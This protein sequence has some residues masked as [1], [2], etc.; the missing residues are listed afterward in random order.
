[1]RIAVVV[2]NNVT[3]DSRVQKIASSALVRGHEVLVIGTSDRRA[4]GPAVVGGAPVV[5]VVSASRYYSRET[6]RELSDRR[7]TVRAERTEALLQHLETRSQRNRG[8][9]LVR[10]TVIRS[11]TVARRIHELREAGRRAVDRQLARRGA[12]VPPLWRVGAG[13]LVDYENALAPVLSAFE[14]DV[15]HV[16]DPHPLAA[17]VELR[18]RLVGERDVTIVYDA[19]EWWEGVNHDGSAFQV[20]LLAVERSHIRE[21]DHVVTVTDEIATR[22]QKGYRL[23]VRPTVVRNVPRAGTQPARGRLTLRAEL[24]LAKQ[25]PLLVYSGTLLQRR[26][27]HDIVSA[28]ADLPEC[29]LALV[30]PPGHPSRAELSARAEALGVG[31]RVH[32][33]DFVPADSVAWYLSDATMGISAL[34][35]SQQHDLAAPTKLAEYVH[36]GLPLVVSDCVTQA[37]LVT[38]TGIGEIFQAGDPSTLAAAVRRALGRTH[39]LRQ[40][41]AE[42]RETDPM[43]WESEFDRLTPLYGGPGEARTRDGVGLIF[44]HADLVSLPWAEAP[45]LV[46]RRRSQPDMAVALTRVLSLRGRRLVVSDGSPTCFAGIGPQPWQALTLLQAWGTDVAL[47]VR[48]GSDIPADAALALPV[49]VRDPRHLHDVPGA[50]W[51]P[52]VA[53]PGS[54]AAEPDP[55]ADVSLVTYS[56]DLAASVVESLRRALAPRDIELLP[57]ATWNAEAGLHVDSWTGEAG[58]Q[59]VVDFLAGGAGVIAPAGSSPSPVAA[60]PVVLADPDEMTAVVVGLIDDGE[61]RDALRRQSMAYV[62]EHHDPDVVL[63]VLLAAA[64][65]SRATAS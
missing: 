47:L 38:R 60:R 16:N 27:V 23:P 5:R 33:T 41:V 58:E 57:A 18:D 7:H 30:A 35:R 21:V 3:G 12:Q 28:L 11:R 36:A 14:P 52:M 65:G 4:S 61:R 49:L 55:A 26:G 54:R 53:S 29:H 8:W 32:I 19:H 62:R 63:E 39:E 34:Q 2:M 6:L 37:E 15:V 56:E 20:G 24:G 45:M 10:S 42:L 44:P 50:A 59:R 1:M 17:A 22:L 9:R 43:D 51:L 46:Q 25:V 64:A 13:Q 48:A 40:R 31:D